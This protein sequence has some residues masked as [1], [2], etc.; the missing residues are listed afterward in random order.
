MKIASAWSGHDCSFCILDNGRPVVH[1]E[2]ER[3]IREKEPYG[4]GVQFMFDEYSEHNDIKHF[5]TVHLSEKL[6]A[7]KESYEKINNIVD[8]N[9]GEFHVI[10]HHQAHAANAFFSSNFQEALILTMDGG[11][12]ENINRL[13]T[14]F[15]IWS[16]E[17]TK[18]KH[19]HTFPLSQLNIGGVWTRVTRYVFNLQ[20]GWP[21]G[22]QAGTVMAMAAMGDREKYFDDFMVMLTKDMAA[23]AHK[24]HNQPRGANVG[25]DPKHPYLNKWRAIADQSEQDKFDLAAGLQYATEEYLKGLI[26]N[27][28][29]QVPAHRNICFAGGVALNSVV[30]GKMLDWF[31]NRVDNMYVT[32]TPH[33]GGLTLGAAQYVWHHVLD[34]PRIRWEDNYT[35]YLGFTYGKDKIMAAVDKNKDNVIYDECDIDKVVDLLDEQNIVAVFGGGSE[36]G[37]RALGNRSILADPRS[38]DMKDKINFK[39]KH[40]QWFRPFAPSILREHVSSW[41]TKDIDSPYMSFVVDF[42]DEV[43]EKVPAVVHLNGS[44]RLQTVT[45]S[46]NESYYDLLSRWNKK[47]GVPILLN[48]SFN[49]RE[50]I[51]ETPEHAINCYLKTEID[52]LYFYD[53]GILVSRK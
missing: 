20:S 12:M 23:A 10:G 35:P 18:I 48:T 27:I 32:P 52:Y 11:G 16:G 37:R 46:D 9:G 29:D 49:D 4:D 45:K 24:P 40:R 1:A 2:Y 53:E 51:C 41:F 15:T 44:A 43:K 14:A 31:S 13:T 36:S 19:L 47:S 21:T 34:N 6:E 42:R 8:S 25:T 22:H 33:D 30:M 28:L 38:P 50:P 39:V 7:Y 26:Q 5:A 3:Y 17:G